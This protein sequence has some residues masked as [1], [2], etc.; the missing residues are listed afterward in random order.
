MTTTIMLSADECA[1]RHLK[2]ADYV[3][4][5][6]AFIDCRIPGSMPKENFS[7]IGPGVTQN[8]S[9]VINLREP[10]GFNIGAAGMHPGI[11]NNLHL[12]FTT[13]VFINTAGR[14]LLRWGVKGDEGELVLEPGDIACIPTWI[15]RGF[16]A[17]SNEYGF[18]M[19]VLG[20]DDTGGIIWSPDVLT[21]ARATGMW[22]SKENTVIDMG[23]S[24]AIPA[25][26]DLM[27]LMPES[28]LAT[29]KRWTVD[30]MRARVVTKSTR[31]FKPATLDCAAG[32]RWEIAPVIGY[33]LSQYRSHISAVN[34]A[35]GF[36][37]EW[38]RVP[39]G[40]GSAAF[41]LAEK[42]VVICQRGALEINV[43]AVPQVVATTLGE[44][45]MF[46]IPA[47]TVRSF[48]NRG[49]VPC[50]AGIVIAGDARKRAVFDEATIA[51]ALQNDCA[52]DASGLMA[53]ASILPP[54]MLS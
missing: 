16:S 29:L 48:A 24:G 25:A 8:P 5:T 9:Q 38:M 34:E 3:P 22:L 49:D 31:D 30:E 7:M 35:L 42:M 13:E 19:T 28:E 6:D 1:R 51:A 2:R 50:E 47:H 45:D 18:L 15:F 39:V 53:R 10:H 36:S 4:C 17:L 12:H 33:G 46:S 52:L 40:G 11:T 20:G 32:S 54:A 37:V 21:R 27:P 14:Y 23:D 44:W 43:N 26:Q 41:M